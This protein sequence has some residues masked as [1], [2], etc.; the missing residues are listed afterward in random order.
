MDLTA[1]GG[2]AGCVGEN[3]SQAEIRD[4]HAGR[5]KAR[6]E[7]AVGWG[8]LQ[9]KSTDMAEDHS[10]RPALGTFVTATVGV[11]EAIC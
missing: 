3:A 7:W 1:V 4:S 10:K 2:R 9:S 11:N 6:P 8:F 5:K